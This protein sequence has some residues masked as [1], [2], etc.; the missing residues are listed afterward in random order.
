[1]LQREHRQHGG[2][3]GG[4]DGHGVPGRK[5]LRH[6]DQPITAHPRL[7]REATVVRLAQSPSGCQHTVARDEA[8]IGRRLDDTGKV[9]ARNQRKLA[10]D[11]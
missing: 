6:L 2:E 4:S 10:N 5:D 3:P 7:L 8:G 9:D 11:R 1:M